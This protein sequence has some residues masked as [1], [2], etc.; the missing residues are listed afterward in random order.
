MCGRF[1]LTDPRQHIPSLFDLPAPE[2]SPRYNVAPTQP[3]AALR[4]APGGAREVA[5]LRWGLVPS[6]AKDLSV[7]SRMINARAETLVERAAFREALRRRR[8]LVAADGFYEWRDK[9]PHHFHFKDGKPFAFAGL[10]ERW[11]GSDGA[12]VET[13]TIISAPAQGVM[14]Q[15]HHRMAVSLPK[16]LFAD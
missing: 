7:G 15:Y 16:D 12:P 9:Q 4:E 8:C 14:T 10:W 5:L 11:T 3:V 6:W 13:C 1:T 2:M